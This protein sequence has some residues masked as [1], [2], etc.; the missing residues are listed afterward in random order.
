VPV[1]GSFDF[2]R[3]DT[4]VPLPVHVG[5]D[6]DQGAI[7]GFYELKGNWC[8]PLWEIINRLKELF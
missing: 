1:S 6:I 5:L 8:E 3:F 7:M 4:A 2:E